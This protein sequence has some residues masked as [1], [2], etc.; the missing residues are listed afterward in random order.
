MKNFL[1]GVMFTVFLMPLLSAQKSFPVAG[2]CISVP[3]PD[4]IDEFVVFIEKE[5]VTRKVNTLVLRVDYNFLFT[6]H[7]EINNRHAISREHAKKI[8]DVCRKHSIRLIPLVNLLGHQ[9]WETQIGSLLKAHPEFDET[10][11]IPLPK[12]Y[13]WPNPDGLYCKSYCPLHPEV[14]QVVFDL[15]DEICAAF[16]ADALHAGMDEVFYIGHDSCERCRG[17]NKAEL[18]AGEV[19]L[20][21]DH[22]REKNR[23][24]WIWGDRLLDGKTT[25]IGMW[26]ASENG[27][28]PA[29]DLIYKDITICDWHYDIAVPTP[30][31]FAMKGFKVISCPWQKPD[32]ALTQYQD[33]ID[34][35]KNSPAHMKERYQGVMQT[36]WYG[37]GRFM[38]ELESRKEPG[39]ISEASCFT[40]LFNAINLKMDEPK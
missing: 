20:I 27:T 18:F 25:G 30:V 33:M 39:K 37:T 7:P 24:L 8:L 34:F 1:I 40:E 9:S 6:S 17:Q 5:L 15:I 11:G 12:K 38:Q 28:Y 14:H 35:R 2:I 31:Y 23:E 16:D 19:N 32:V 21:R 26:E 3:E 4:E 29:I 10:P 36:V 13:S 22:L